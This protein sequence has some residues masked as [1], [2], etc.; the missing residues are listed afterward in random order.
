MVVRLVAILLYRALMY[1][2]GKHTVS[3]LL[4]A[5]KMLIY[6]WALARFKDRV[7]PTCEPETWMT[8]EEAAFVFQLTLEICTFLVAQGCG[9]SEQYVT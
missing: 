2:T 8:V 1:F 4:T 6:L 7:I 3:T 5:T 9:K